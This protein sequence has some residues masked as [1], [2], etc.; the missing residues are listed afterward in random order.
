MSRS[1]SI[2]ALIVLTTLLCCSARAEILWSDEG[3]R[4]FR[5]TGAGEDNLGGKVR[6]DDQ[7]NDVLYF[8]FHV[9]PISDA[10]SEPYFAGFQL[11]EGDAE[12]F[13]VGNALEAW[14]YSA[15]NTAE[16]GLSNKVAGEF[17]LNSADPEPAHLG[18]FWPYEV[19][20]H[21]VERTIV[22]K[23][24]YV[25][26]EDALVT[27]CNMRQRAATIGGKLD[28]QSTPNG[29]SVKLTVNLAGGKNPKP[30]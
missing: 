13:G 29:T 22:F 8:K 11:F 9:N 15:F 16:I 7:A 6:R 1:A 28:L 20:H 25:P 26:G 19:V 2:F 21:G 5:N 4:V 23:I 12:R 3:A 30:A 14:G 17:N 18:L 24:Q 10:E 27:V